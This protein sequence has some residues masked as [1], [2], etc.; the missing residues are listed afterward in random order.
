MKI[1]F[2]GREWNLQFTNYTE[3][4]SVCL[5]LT[6]DDNDP[7]DYM[8]VTVNMPEPL[9][10]EDMVAIKDYAENEG[11]LKVMI[12]AGVVSEPLGTMPSGYVDFP[13]CRLLVTE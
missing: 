4:D 6:G 2:N 5:L 1:T 13:I 10:D 7:A 9:P 3:N 8:K 12:D 11:M